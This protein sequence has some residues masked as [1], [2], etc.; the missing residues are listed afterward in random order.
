MGKYDEMSTR[1]LQ[2]LA[3]ERNLKTS[4]TKGELVERL[5]DYDTASTP[6]PAEEEAPPVVRVEPSTRYTPAAWREGA[7]LKVAFQFNGRL[8]EERKTYFNEQVGLHAEAQGLI[9]VGEPGLLFSQG[10]L[11]L[12]GVEVQ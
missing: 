9:A 4:R 7:Y 10:A 8:T 1:D 5:E 11:T 3:V 12:Y 6:P 2:K